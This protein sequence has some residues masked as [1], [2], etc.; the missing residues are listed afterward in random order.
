MTRPSARYAP[1]L[2]VLGLLTAAPVAFHRLERPRNDE[3]AD[4]EALREVPRLAGSGRPVERWEK[5][6]PEVIQWTEAGLPVPGQREDLRAAVIRSYKPIGLYTRT[7]RLVL[8]PF[9]AEQQGIRTVEA[10]DRQ[11]PVQT[12]FDGT[13][14]RNAMASYLFLYQGEPVAHPFVAQL[15]DAP[16]QL[17]TG[18]HPL[19]VILVGGEV[20]RARRGQAQ[21]VAG[22]FI[23]AAWRHYRESCFPAAAG[24]SS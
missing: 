21:E 7:P 2:L 14:G 16:S 20:P 5:H 6:G 12:V 23:A 13:H 17:F 19:T 3:C 24:S 18:T 15:L 4:P 9:E 10:G 8:G 22:R 11:L 1:L